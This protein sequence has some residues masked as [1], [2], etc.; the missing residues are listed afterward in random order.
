[1]NAFT[2]SEMAEMAEEAGV[3]NLTVKRHF[4]YRIGLVGTKK[5]T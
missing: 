4:P 2:P 5:K 3:K 1:M